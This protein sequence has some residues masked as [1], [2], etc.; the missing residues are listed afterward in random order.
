M[1]KGIEFVELNLTIKNAAGALVQFGL[2]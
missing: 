1:R 2:K